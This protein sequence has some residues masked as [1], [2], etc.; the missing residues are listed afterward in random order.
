M[1]GLFFLRLHSFALQVVDTHS[2]SARSLDSDTIG[3][4]SI[5]RRGRR[6]G[7]LDREPVVAVLSTA[8]EGVSW[9]VTLAGR[10]SVPLAEVAGPRIDLG[11]TGNPADFL[12]RLQGLLSSTLPSAAG[13]VL[14]TAQA[15]VVWV[16][17]QD[18]AQHV[19]RLNSKMQHAP[20]LAYN[21]LAVLC[22][23]HHRDQAT[24]AS[25]QQPVSFL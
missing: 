2:P 13:P 16:R 10:A 20:S 6:N 7:A 9:R 19:R 15:Q 14:L 12:A 8:W 3:P 24:V 23:S 22:R 11:Q 5:L 21:W 17:R 25:S 1:G 4:V 18:R